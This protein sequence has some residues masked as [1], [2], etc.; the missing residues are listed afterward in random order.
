[1]DEQTVFWLQYLASVGGAG[2]A[3]DYFFGWIRIGVPK[4][5]VLSWSRATAAQRVG[6]ALVWA[7]RY[8]RLVVFVLSSVI[9]IIATLMLSSITGEPVQPLPA[10]LAAI[11]VSQITHGVRLPGQVKGMYD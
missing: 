8:A 1:V 7:P 9:A 3:A 4:P 2:W 11:V 5:D 6:W 10:V